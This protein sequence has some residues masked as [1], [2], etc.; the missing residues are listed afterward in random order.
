MKTLKSKRFSGDSDLGLVLNGGLRLAAAGTEP[1]PAPVLSNGAPIVA[2]QQALIDIGYP[3]PAFGADGAFGSE[4]GSAVVKFKKDWQ[5]MPD[6]PVIGPRTILALDKEMIAF[7]RPT[8]EPPPPPLPSPPGDPFG[9]TPAG[10]AKLPAALAIVAAFGAKGTGSNWLHLN[11]SKVAAAIADRINNPDGAQ[12]GG[13][14]LCTVAAFINVWAQ[15]APDSYAAFATALFDNASAN[16]APDQMGR[17]LR[18]KVTNAL[19]EADYNRIATR[20]TEKKF[21]VPS[22]A[23]W[24]VMS[25]IRDS[26]N[27]VTPFTGDPDD[28]VSHVLGDGSFS[29]ELDTWL[30]N[31]GAWGGGVIRVSN[32]LL[33]ATLEEA[34]RLEPIRSRCLLEIDVGML[35]NSTGG[36]TVVLR[37]P[38]TQTPDGVVTLKV[39]SWAGL[40]DVRVTKEKFEDTYHGAN[41]AFL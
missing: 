19:L 27:V 15:D 41:V 20:M 25:A 13:N 30:R 40:R 14:G 9:R 16:L 21:P 39:W 7:E 23:D 11:R 8:P 22:Q 10:L 36:H 4:L 18:I 29:S 38:I 35:N 1:F 26:S 17:G 32:D 33:T 37:S 3:L 5:I 6:D 31:A 2:V 24:M 34:K 12:Q 28:W